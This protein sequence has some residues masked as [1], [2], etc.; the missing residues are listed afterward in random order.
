MTSNHT[1]ILIIGAGVAGIATGTMLRRRGITD[2]TII[3]RGETFGGTW[4]DNV[5]PGVECDVQSHLYS[6]SFR[7]NPRWSK[8]YA[9][10]A[11]INDYLVTVA[12]EEGLAENT[13]FNRSVL[14]V[15]WNTGTQTWIVTTDHETYEANY[16]VTATGSLAEP[17]MPKIPGIEG[18]EGDLMHSAMWDSSIDLKGKRVAVIG[19]GASAIQVV[20]AIANDVESLTVFQRTPPWIVPRVDIKYSEA[21]KRMWESLPETLEEYRQFLFWLHETRFP[22][23]ARAQAAIDRMTGIANAHRENQIQDPELREMTRP[24]YAIGCKRILNSNDWYP[25]LQRENVELVPYAAEKMTETGIIDAAGA[26]R[27]FDVIIVCTGYDTEGLPI[28]RIIHGE[29]DTRLSDLWAEEGARAYGGMSVDG[30]PNF[31]FVNG[32]HVGLGFGSIIF[33]IETQAGHVADALRFAMDSDTP[34]IRVRPDRQRSFTD[35]LDER[36]ARTVWLTGG[37]DSFYL[38]DGTGRLT[39]LWP[40]FMTRFADDFGTFNV[41]DYVLEPSK[42][43]VA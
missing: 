25:T 26:E 42:Y 15:R 37:C 33:M 12:Q 21:Q 14:E 31:F 32:P 4:R 20:P 17:K 38:G 19:T 35:F 9:G 18:F 34:T 22:E 6:F 36:A 1:P 7:H 30:F 8:T 10:G 41:D 3:D 5:Y 28:T 24:T 13:V 43:A 40:D 11:E 29:D 16:V 23:R 2:F 27:D 39:S